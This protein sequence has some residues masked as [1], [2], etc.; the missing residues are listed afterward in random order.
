MKEIT[1]YTD[2]GCLGNNTRT[3]VDERMIRYAVLKENGEIVF[4]K[5]DIGGSNNI[6]ELLGVLEALRYADENGYSRLVVKTD[7]MNNF[8]WVYGHKVGNKIN[9]RTRTLAIKKEITTLRRMIEIE[10]IFVPRE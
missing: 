6:A 1:L 7:S 9:D 2:G 5:T 8:A 4:D 3:H 10:L